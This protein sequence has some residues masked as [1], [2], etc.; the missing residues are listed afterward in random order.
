M[1]FNKCGEE[2]ISLPEP[3]NTYKFAQNDWIVLSVQNGKALLLSDKIIERRR[4]HHSYTDI[5]WSECDLR[6]YLNGLNQYLGKGFYDSFKAQD[7]ARIA[8]TRITTENNPWFGTNGGGFTDD[9]I[10]ILSLEDVCGFI[11]TTF[12]GN[13]SDALENG[14]NN[15]DCQ[16]WKDAKLWVD[17]EAELGEER[18]Y[19]ALWIS[20]VNNDNRMAKCGD[21]EGTWWWWLRSPGGYGYRTASVR[22]SGAVT[23]R[24][25]SV[26]YIDGGVRPALWL[27]L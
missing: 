17:A 24:G 2:W 25:H 7:K 23:V 11:G 6:D 20:D 16:V 13:S 1:Q 4:Y 5:T 26:T 15:P 14:K 21:K 8:K 10:F 27:N 12:F 22:Q 18:L 3:D 19:K 9:Y